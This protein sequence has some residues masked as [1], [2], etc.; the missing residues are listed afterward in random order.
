MSIDPVVQ[1]W[2]SPYAA[3]GNNPIYYSDP[4]GDFKTWFGAFLYKLRHGGQISKDIGGEYYVGKEL[5]N[6]VWS[7]ETK[8]LANGGIEK[9]FYT[10]V[11]YQRRF[12]W[13]G[14]SVGRGN[15]GD[16]HNWISNARTTAGM[17]MMWATGY[18][19]P[20]G[21]GSRYNNDA[22]AGA[23]RNAWK[24]GEAREAFYNKYKGVSNLTGASLT[25]YKGN[26]GVEGYFRAGIDPIEQFVGS[27]RIDIHAI[28]GMLRFTLT[29]TTSFKSLMYGVGPDWQGGPM[30]NFNQTYIFTEPIR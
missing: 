18:R 19:M 6:R 5:S 7:G 2:E 25:N 30:G 26:F 23:M 27:Y 28:D 11:S 17:T 21:A 1:P 14:R 22:V 16:G 15:P 13:K 10:E 8:V 24:V 4:L 29:N 9:T 20:F 12:D 3:M